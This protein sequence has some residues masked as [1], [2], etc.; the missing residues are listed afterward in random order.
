MLKQGVLIGLGLSLVLSGV[1]GTNYEV[2]AE[3]SKS[4]NKVSS[5][6]TTATIYK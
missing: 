4:T 1:T 6:K 3:T 2:K 5:S